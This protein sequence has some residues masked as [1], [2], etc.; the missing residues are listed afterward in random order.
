MGRLLLTPISL[1]ISKVV[2]STSTKS[3]R[4]SENDSKVRNKPH[5]ATSGSATTTASVFTRLFKSDNRKTKDEV[6]QRWNFDN[7]SSDADSVID[8]LKPT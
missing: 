7:I 6:M 8:G 1:R 4:T 2:E 5:D 3:K